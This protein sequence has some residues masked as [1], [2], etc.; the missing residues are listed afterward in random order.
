MDVYLIYNSILVLRFGSKFFWAFSH[1]SLESIGRVYASHDFVV[2]P[3]A[4]PNLIFLCS[5]TGRRMSIHV[6]V[7]EPNENICKVVGN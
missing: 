7:G 5:F 6:V 1:F 3:Y 4:L 2:I